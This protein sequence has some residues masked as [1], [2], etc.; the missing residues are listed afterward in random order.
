MFTR[1][2]QLLLRDDECPEHLRGVEVA[3]EEVRIRWL[4]DRIEVI[5]LGRTDE[6]RVERLR[7]DRRCRRG[8]R[9]ERDVMS[10]RVFVVERDGELL[11]GR[12][13]KAAG[14]EGCVLS[15]DLE[16]RTR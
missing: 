2:S 1:M 15:G 16:T 8:V 7:L 13:G 5:R 12:N 3:T 11:A 4:R 10:E 14:A 6:G 9:V